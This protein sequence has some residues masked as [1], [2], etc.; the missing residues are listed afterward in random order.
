MK[1]KQTII[2]A[3][4]NALRGWW[5]FFLHERNGKIQLVVAALTIVIAV[6]LGVTI[7]EW[8]IILLCIAL[9]IGGEMMNCAIEKLCDVVQEDYHPIIKI[10]KD[11]AAGVVLLFAFVSLIIG[12]IIFLK[13]L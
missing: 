2:Q 11:V 13:Y 4:K 7:T 12:V 9:V 6:G 3:F 8:L 1:Q 5:Y 10:I